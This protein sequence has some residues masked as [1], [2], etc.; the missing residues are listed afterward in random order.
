MAASHLLGPDGWP[1]DGLPPQACSLE[2]RKHVLSLVPYF[3]GLDEA[4]LE[5]VHAA[6]HATHLTRGSVIVTEAEPAEAFYVIA[7][8]RVKLT[9]ATAGGAEHL[10]DVLGPGDSFGALPLLGQARH[11]AS[12]EALTGGCL[13]VTSASE[14]GELVTAFPRVAVAVLED[15][16]ARLR[17]AQA[18][19]RDAAGSTVEARLAA[20]LLTLSSRLGEPLETGG[21]SLGAPLSQEDLAAL[22]GSTLE[23]INRVLA[24]WRAR[25][26]VETGRRRIVL[27]DPEALRVVS[28]G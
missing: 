7:S 25:G 16:S 22:A 2:L 12:A 24:Q 18:R 1:E 9:Q 14:F 17:D 8:G 3:S 19:L 11:D 26:L 20:S 27:L 15:V 28:G 4:A 21:R 5:R 23:T 6:F 10:L 13:L